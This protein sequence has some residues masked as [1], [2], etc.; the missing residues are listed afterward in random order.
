MRIVYFYSLWYVAP[1]NFALLVGAAL[2]IAYSVIVTFL[3]NTLEWSVETGVSCFYAIFLFVHFIPSF[4]GIE[5]RTH[6]YRVLKLC[7][8]PGA[9]IT[10]PE[11]LLA[12][13][14]CSLSKVLKD[15]GTSLVAV[16]SHFDGTSIVDH[17]DNAMILVAVLASL[18]FA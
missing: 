16:F 7:F 9:S 5:S 8:F 4:P 1:M 6:F 13:A 3:A 15:I 12:D 18:P 11:I 14:L 17:H 2:G 10:F